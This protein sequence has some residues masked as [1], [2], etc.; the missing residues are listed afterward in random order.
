MPPTLPLKCRA[1]EAV[2]PTEDLRARH[3]TETE[4]FRYRFPCFMCPRVFESHED[5]AAHMDATGHFQFRCK[6]CG[7]HFEKKEALV[8]HLRSPVHR[9]LVHKCQYCP[10]VFG[11]PSAVIHH[12]ESNC[13][14]NATGFNVESIYQIMKNLDKEEVFTIPVVQPSGNT[15]IEFKM[16]GKWFHCTHCPARFKREIGLVAHLQS[17]VHRPRQ[18]HCFNAP[19]RCGKTFLTLASL[20]NHLESESC[21][22]YNFDD[23]EEVYGIIKKAVADN[24]RL[25]FVDLAV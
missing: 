25:S 1:C 23:V 19:N 24:R 9:A 22:I 20:F 7:E 14:E 3:E 15:N 12:V 17:P 5:A 2:F 10:S 21:G 11:T 4:H 18:Y 6:K 13:C 8:M 16:I